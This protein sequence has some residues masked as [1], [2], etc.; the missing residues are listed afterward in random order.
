MIARHQQD[1]GDSRY[2]PFTYMLG[3]YDNP[4]SHT[5]VALA[6]SYQNI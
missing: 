5:Y 1:S 3:A 6:A 4:E 2:L